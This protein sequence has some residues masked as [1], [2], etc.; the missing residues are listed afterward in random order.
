[1]AGDQTDK[2]FLVLFFKKEQALF[3]KKEAKTFHPFFA[4]RRA[5]VECR[6]TRS[7][8][9]RY[10][11]APGE[12]ETQ[13]RAAFLCFLLGLLLAACTAEQ[14]ARSSYAGARNA[15]LD[16]PHQCTVHPDQD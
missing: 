14:V 10:G 12:T 9:Y 5:G 4:D 2:S 7:D 6:L 8:R 15:C 1:V 11:P 16:N 13:M 3:L